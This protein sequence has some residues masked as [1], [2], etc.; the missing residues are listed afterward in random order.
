[1]PVAIPIGTIYLAEGAEVI[2]GY[3]PQGTG[4]YVGQRIATPG[5]TIT[6]GSTFLFTGQGIR[7]TGPSHD[8]AIEYLY[9]VKNFGATGSFTLL[10]GGLI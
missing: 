7:N 10:V 1:V 6:S 2:Y 4:D 8:P 5:P 3:K 9:R